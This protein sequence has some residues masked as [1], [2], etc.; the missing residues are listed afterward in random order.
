MGTRPSRA[1]DFSITSSAKT[2]P[3]RSCVRSRAHTTSSADGVK[4]SR[5]SRSEIS[6]MNLGYA[7]R[8]SDATPTAPRPTA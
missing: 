4:N 8:S 6:L 2:R 5:N 1:A 7:V 3:G